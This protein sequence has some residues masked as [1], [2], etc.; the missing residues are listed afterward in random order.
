MLNHK[1]AKRISRIAA[2]QVMYQK[3]VT[4]NDISSIIDNV[5]DFIEEDEELECKM[6]RN[7]FKRLVS[8]FE[9]KVDFDDIIEHNL[10]SKTSM[11]TS[12]MIMKSIIKVGIT[13]M[14][15]EKTAIP[16]I[17]NEYVEIAK[18]FIGGGGEK[19][20]NAVLDK[21]ATNVKRRCEIKT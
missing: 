16:I 20:V 12:P 10:V 4:N 9:E 17:I 18:K 13:E 21:I 2:V 8:N 5:S 15:F 14:I 7:F 19:F 1:L 11:I 6:H 3:D